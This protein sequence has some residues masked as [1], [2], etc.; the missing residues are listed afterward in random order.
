M[1]IFHYHK[2][3]PELRFVFSCIFLQ[4]RC[5]SRSLMLR[6]TSAATA[7]IATIAIVLLFIILVYKLN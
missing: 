5:Q 6:L 7:A 3:L 4:M 2:R 1:V